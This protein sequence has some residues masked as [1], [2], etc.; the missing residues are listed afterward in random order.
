MYI[1][2]LENMLI[3]LNAKQITRVSTLATILIV[4][5]YW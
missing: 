3:N 1:Q 2:E 4:S 5:N